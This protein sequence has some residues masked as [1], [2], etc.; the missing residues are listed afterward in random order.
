MNIDLNPQKTEVSEW[1]IAGRKKFKNKDDDNLFQFDEEIPSPR[2]K[3]SSRRSAL[4]VKHEDEED[5]E[6]D[7]DNETLARLI[8]VTSTAAKKSRIQ[9][10]QPSMT[11][12]FINIINE[13]LY[14]FEQNNTKTK[15]SKLI[16]ETPHI[17]S[18]AQRLYPK[19]SENENDIGWIISKQQ[20]PNHTPTSSPSSSPLDKKFPY[21]QHPSHQLLEERGFVQHKYHK[22]Y[23]NC[24]KER[25]KLGP[26]Q[27]SEMNTLYRFWSHFLRTHFNKQIYDEFK[28]KNL[29]LR[30]QKQIRDMA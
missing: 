14:Y 25:E 26:G 10:T 30:M 13:G 19:K 12:D 3:Q 18:K 17:P 7:I 22:Y 11:D 4:K 27:S 28:K 2:E 9:N 6:K 23:S 15:D 1:K 21:F 16:N 29:L 5:D 8:I 20:T 24:I